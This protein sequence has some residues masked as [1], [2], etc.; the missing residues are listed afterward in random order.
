MLL[1]RFSIKLQ[2]FPIH[3]IL[4]VSPL[5]FNLALEYVIWKVQENQVGLKLTGTHQLLAYADDVNL[6]V[7]NIVITNKNTNKQ[8]KQTPWPLVRERTIPTDRPPLVDEI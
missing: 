1:V 3:L 8:N 6:L 2:K 7:D 5:L 4:P